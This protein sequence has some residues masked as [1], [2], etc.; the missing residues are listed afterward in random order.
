MEVEAAIYST[1]LGQLIIY[2]REDLSA[3]WARLLQLSQEDFDREMR[4]PNQ[5]L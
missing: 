1:A 4:Q 3:E 2:K 5:L